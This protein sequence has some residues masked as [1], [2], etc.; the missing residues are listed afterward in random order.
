VKYSLTFSASH[1]GLLGLA[2]P[3]ASKITQHSLSLANTF[4]ALGVTA[5]LGRTLSV[6]D[7]RSSKEQNVAVISYRYW[8]QQ[9]AGDSSIIGKGVIVSGVPFTIVGVMPRSFYGTSL[10][11]SVDLWLPI[12]MQQ[13]IDGGTSDMESTGINWV[14]VMARLKSGVSPERAAVVANTLHQRYLRSSNADPRLLEQRIRIEAGGRPVSGIRGDLVAPLVTLM[15]IVVLV[16]LLACA[17]I[18]NFTLARG[19]ARSREMAVRL[20]I[21][22]GRRRVIQQLLTES[23]LLASLGSVVGIGVA[24][25]G[26]RALLDVVAKA[27]SQSVPTQLQFHADLRL[28]TFTVG[29]SLLAAVLFG[30][31]PALQATKVSIVPS[32]ER[33]YRYR[34]LSTLAPE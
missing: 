32:P 7:P 19:V 1:T 9:F 20:A 34:F 4:A 30:L 21:G 23:L 12:T 6:E 13:R 17:N 18:A 2:S 10:D 33:A 15:A 25:V 5:I 8:Q 26:D 29:V 22:A 28:L 24:L 14:I 11:Y 3:G 16:L 31:V 27:T